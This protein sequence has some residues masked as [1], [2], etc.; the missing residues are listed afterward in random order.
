MLG[1]IGSRMWLVTRARNS[2]AS[3]VMTEAPSGAGRVR[4][5]VRTGTKVSSGRTSPS[6]ARTWMW[7]WKVRSWP[8]VCNRTWDRAAAGFVV[9]R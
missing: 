5:M 6:V 8:N 1:G 2:S 3:S 7:G 9:K 4:R